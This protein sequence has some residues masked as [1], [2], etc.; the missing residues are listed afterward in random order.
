MRCTHKPTLPTPHTDKT[1]HIKAAFNFTPYDKPMEASS[2]VVT[3]SAMDS[4]FAL[5][6]SSTY[7]NTL[8][9]SAAGMGAGASS[10][11]APQTGGDA[12]P[13]SS[14]PVLAGRK[15]PQ[16]DKPASAELQVTTRRWGKGG[17]IVKK[18][19]PSVPASSGMDAQA[20]AGDARSSSQYEADASAGD[21]SSS[22]AAAGSLA[23]SAASSGL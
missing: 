12:P 5:P 13:G 22:A 14:S 21:S 17:D 23:S 4:I 10:L 3:N 11:A 7:G 9:S 1:A 19:P 15:V 18:A 2:A 16:L 20:R 6:P 8:S